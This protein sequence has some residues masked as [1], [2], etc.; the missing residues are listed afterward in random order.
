MLRSAGGLKEHSTYHDLVFVSQF[1]VSTAIAPVRAR[2]LTNRYLSG[3][4]PGV[5]LRFDNFLDLSAVLQDHSE[6]RL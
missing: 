3:G 5:C 4:T 2:A 1:I 6:D